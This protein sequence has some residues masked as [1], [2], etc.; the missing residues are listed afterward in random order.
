VR[1]VTFALELKTFQ[2]TVEY[3]RLMAATTMVP[4]ADQ[5]KPGNILAKMQIGAELDIP[6]MTAIRHLYVVDGRVSMEVP[7]M[8]ALV[9]RSGLLEDKTIEELSDGGCRVSVHRKGR[10]K[11]RAITF[12]PEQAKK[13]G[14]TGKDNYKHWDWRMYYNRAMGFALQD[15]FADVL[16][17]VVSPEYMQ[18]AGLTI[19]AQTV[20][21]E[22]PEGQKA[23]PP[24]SLD[25]QQE[26]M[27]LFDQLGT[28]PAGRLVRIKQ[29]K[30]REAELI[31]TLKAEVAKK[32]PT[33]VDKPAQP[34]P[35]PTAEELAAAVED[36]AA[37]Q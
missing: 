33:P 24:P 11:P 25:M 1:N 22:P 8:L 17:G 9:E 2:E 15:E 30:G 6:M 27:R 16:K 28:K 3:A 31:E 4:A 26:M 5:G 36:K 19:D 34:T 23:L 35:Q 37:A 10:S 14:L 13:A 20:G 12:G 18:D 7:L 21:A 32:L 29:N